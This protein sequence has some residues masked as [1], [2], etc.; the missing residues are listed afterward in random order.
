M[1]RINQDGLTLVELLVVIAII[2]TLVALLM[3][4]LS[5]VKARAQ[6]IRCGSNVRQLGRG[7]HE[8][9]SDNHVYPLYIDTVN[10]NSGQPTVNVYW[11]DEVGKAL[12]KIS[13]RLNRL[14]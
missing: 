13:T 11:N 12:S 3:P 14:R 5:A 4:A 8:F 7:L 6:R 9:V 1:R 2:G 10:E